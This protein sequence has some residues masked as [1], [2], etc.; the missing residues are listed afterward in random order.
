LVNARSRAELEAEVAWSVE[1][2]KREQRVM[3]AE[4]VR[5]LKHS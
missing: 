3:I 5:N 4:F 1:A 2:W